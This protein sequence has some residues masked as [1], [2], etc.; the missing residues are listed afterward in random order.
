M[1][2]QD[3]SIQI[4]QERKASGILV[5]VIADLIV[6]GLLFVGFMDERSKAVSSFNESAAS[7]DSTLGMWNTIILVTSGLMM[8]FA[9]KAA[10]EYRHKH[11]QYF[12]VAAIL[13]GIIFGVNK[14]I[15]YHAKIEVGVTMFTNNFYMFYYAL[16][17]AH[18]LH[19]IGGVAA[20]LYLLIISQNNSSTEKF[21]ELIGPTALYWHMVDLLWILIYPLL[22]L[23][24]S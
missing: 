2:I 11:A 24:R 16:T 21:R 22:Y 14:G 3:K 19:F 10:D 23:L 18:C 5:F 15:E 7:L 6:F 20:L 17:G 4:P 8:V 12:L 1:L 9:V 13:V